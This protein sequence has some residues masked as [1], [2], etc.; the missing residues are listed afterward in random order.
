MS[1]CIV[2]VNSCSPLQFHFRRFLTFNGMF[3]YIFLYFSQCPDVRR[4]AGH[5][6]FPAVVRIITFKMWKCD[7]CWITWEVVDLVS[8][9][10]ARQAVPQTDRQLGRLAH[11]TELKDVVIKLFI[12]RNAQRKWASKK[13]C[14][15]KWTK[16]W[17]ETLK[18]CICQAESRKNR[19]DHVVQRIVRDS[20]WTLT[21]R[22]HSGMP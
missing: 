22:Q 1:H 17:W 4:P 7:K 19:D 5:T 3:I 13:L 20:L 8:A 16:W 18:R 21:M 12:I 15:S 11:E 10:V 2:I 14:C 9:I 6:P